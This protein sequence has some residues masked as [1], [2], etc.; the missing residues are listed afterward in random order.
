MDRPLLHFLLDAIAIRT[1]RFKLPK[2]K[3]VEIKCRIRL[4]F[5]DTY[6]HQWNYIIRV[7]VL[8]FYSTQESVQYKQNNMLPLMVW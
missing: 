7:P 6:L 1:M 5:D 2:K 8:F 4:H 3:T